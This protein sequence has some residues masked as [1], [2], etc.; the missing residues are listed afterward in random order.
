VSNGDVMTRYDDLRWL[1]A[2]VDEAYGKIDNDVVLPLTA[3]ALCSDGIRRNVYAQYP[4][5]N[6]VINIE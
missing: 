4:V 5:V 6:M 3:N 1:I 2:Y